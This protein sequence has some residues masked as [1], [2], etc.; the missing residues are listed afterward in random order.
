MMNIKTTI[1]GLLAIIGGAKMCFS[2][3]WELGLTGIASGVGLVV[4]K[5]HNVTGGTKQ[6][7]GLKQQ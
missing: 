6:Q 2:G 7:N 5:D 3:Q 1:A 4:A